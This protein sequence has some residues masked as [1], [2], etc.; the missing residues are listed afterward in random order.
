MSFFQA[1]G[2]MVLVFGCN[3]LSKKTTG[4]GMW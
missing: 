3:R 4:I 1:A 2:G